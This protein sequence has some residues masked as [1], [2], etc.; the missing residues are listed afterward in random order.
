MTAAE[1]RYDVVIAGGGPAGCAAAL[2]AAR[3]N[4]A[5]LLIEPQQSPCSRG[6]AGW[7]G[8]AGMRMCRELGVDAAAAGAA[9]FAGVRL[10]G[11]DL[12][13]PLDVKDSKLTGWV[14][15]PSRLGAALLAAAR[16]GGVQVL[17][18]AVAGVQLGEDAVRVEVAADGRVG[19]RKAA[20]ERLVTGRV[21]VI[22]DGAG[23]AT[24]QSANLP[25]A[26]GERGACAQ[27]SLDRSE[28]GCGLDV[29]LG[30]G[31]D[32]KVATI[33]WHGR[34]ALV[35]LMTQDS[36]LPAVAQLAEFLH[37]A[38]EKGVL[39][40]AKRVA[41]VALP[42]LAGAALEIETHVGKR[43]LLVG[44]AGGFASAFSND[45][46]YPALR[47]GWLASQTVAEALA[48]PVLQDELAAFSATWRTEL[49]DYLRMPNTDLGLLLPMVFNNVQMARRLALA[50]LLGQAF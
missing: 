42:C 20:G 1:V 26:H 11:W 39:P 47:S 3:R 8:P 15:E 32:L 34:C 2:A 19:T 18:G 49:A 30:A 35:T 14:V 22:A 16:S 4:L 23:S 13:K 46:I 17:R 10:W 38:A 5:A 24:A 45:G 36:T 7:I 37:V 50:F 43:C 9:D 28:P 29:V 12:A 41:P 6:C 40:P 31:R 33:A 44:D 21:L 25:A 48:A 27:V